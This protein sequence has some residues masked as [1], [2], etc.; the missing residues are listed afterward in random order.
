MWYCSYFFGEV[1]WFGEYMRSNH[2]YTHIPIYRNICGY[3]IL[4]LEP[5]K[6]WVRSKLRDWQEFLNTRKRVATPFSICSRGWQVLAQMLLVFQWP[7]KLRMVFTF[8]LVDWPFE[9]EIIVDS[10]AVITHTCITIWKI[11]R[12]TGFIKMKNSGYQWKGNPQNWWKHLQ[13]IHLIS[14]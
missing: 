7:T 8:C 3:S 2:V 10:H 14:D 6:L 9:F 13:T 4:C 1:L 12:W 5:Q 11:I